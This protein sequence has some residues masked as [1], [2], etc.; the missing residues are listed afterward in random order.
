MYGRL[1]P[2]QSDE[3]RIGDQ[4]NLLSW[5]NLLRSRHCHINT[6]TWHYATIRPAAHP[7]EAF[8][9]HIPVAVVDA[10]YSS[11]QFG[12][13]VIDSS[14]PH[15][16]IPRAG[17]MRPFAPG[18]R[19]YCSH[20]TG[21]YLGDVLLSEISPLPVPRLQCTHTCTDAAAA[22]FDTGCLSAAV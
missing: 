13:L 18:G 3:A 9:P 5:H 2:R 19:Y 4:K 17:R 11:D 15:A 14:H 7:N 22:A 16:G 6:G 20:G 8:C 21:W 10:N 12:P 1:S